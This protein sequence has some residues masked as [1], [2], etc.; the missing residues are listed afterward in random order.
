MLGGLTMHHHYYLKLNHIIPIG[1]LYMFRLIRCLHPSNPSSGRYISLCNLI[2]L[3]N[4]H[5]T[6]T[7]ELY[8]I[9]FS[10]R[11]YSRQSLNYT[12][13]LYL[14]KFNTILEN[15]WTA[16]KIKKVTRDYIINLL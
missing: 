14:N 15:G 12:A 1:Q 8:R 4:T 3:I 5:S 6:R 16:A 9:P 10:Y 2:H 13:P 11:E 7:N